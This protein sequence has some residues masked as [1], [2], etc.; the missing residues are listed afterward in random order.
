MVARNTFVFNF[1][2]ENRPSSLDGTEEWRTWSNSQF[3]VARKEAANDRPA[4]GWV[5][6]SEDEP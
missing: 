5:Y 3:T 1:D 2:A 4:D 6:E